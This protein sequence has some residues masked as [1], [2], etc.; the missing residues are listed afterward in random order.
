[1]VVTS[2]DSMNVLFEA[3][4]IDFVGRLAGH[5]RVEAL[6]C[7]LRGAPGGIAGDDADRFHPGRSEGKGPD[8][9]SLPA[10]QK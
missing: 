4:M 7:R 2:K 6:G 5:I 9:L 3:M 10:R 1:M 8:G